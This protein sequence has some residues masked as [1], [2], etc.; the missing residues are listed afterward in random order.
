MFTGFADSTEFASKCASYGITAGPH[1]D[2]PTTVRGASGGGSNG[3][4][5]GTAVNP[6]L[7][8]VAESAY[9]ELEAMFT[10]AGWTVE[11]VHVCRNTSTQYGIYF[12]YGATNANGEY[13]WT[14]GIMKAEYMTNGEIWA[15]LGEGYLWNEGPTEYDTCGNS[16]WI[17]CKKL[18]YTGM[19]W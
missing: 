5:N 6:N 19:N 8:A 3:G 14:D 12:R 18:I 4:S 7:Q 1:I 13:G 15:I 9:R 11:D 2:I 16:Y 17:A 10:S